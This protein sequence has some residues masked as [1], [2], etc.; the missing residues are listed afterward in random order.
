MKWYGLLRQTISL[1][2]FKGCLPKF[3]LAYSW[4]LC[5]IYYTVIE[6]RLFTKKAYLEW[7]KA[8]RNSSKFT[9]RKYHI[10]TMEIHK[11]FLME[12][13]ITVSN[14]P[15]LTIY[16]TKVILD[17]WSISGVAQKNQQKKLGILHWDK[18][19]EE[20]REWLR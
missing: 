1:Q 20:K 9:I 15:R 3:Y 5:L 11:L 12:I 16:F 19:G 17:I 13:Y 8:E 7:V 18:S 10:N 6:L 14:F 2:I 4:I